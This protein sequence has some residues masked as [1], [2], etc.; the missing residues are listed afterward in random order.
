MQVVILA[1][2]LGTRLGS[3]TRD[4]PKPMVP[5]AGVPYLEHQLRIIGEQGIRRIV[6]L[7]GYLG[8]QIEEYFG[9]G[10]RLGLDIRYSRETTPLGTGGA[11]RLAAP[12]LDD[13]FLLLYGDSYLPIQYADVL[14]SLR[15]SSIG[16]T[17]IYDNTQADTMVLNN[18]AI[19]DEGRVTRY[20]KDGNEGELRYV[21][22]GVHAL[23]KSVLR[24][25]PANPVVSLE[26]DIFPKLIEDGRLH[27]HITDQR[28]YDIGTPERLKVIEELF[29]HDHHQN[30]VPR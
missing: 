3:L 22:A 17:V 7:T 30:T 19:D 10:K 14:G 25:F 24:Y 15:R 13:E 6:L 29:H 8:E 20:R 16:A 26:N 9:T 12:L 27:C 28:F 1:G 21:E 5:V 23:R 11:L 4:T 18:I 2:G